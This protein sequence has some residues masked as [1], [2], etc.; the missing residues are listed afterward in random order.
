MSI[1]SLAFNAL[2]GLVSNK[3]Y[4]DLNDAGTAA[5]YIVYSRAGGTEAVFLE[6]AVSSK[7]TPRLQVTCWHTT[8]IGANAL[9]EQALAA[10]VALG[11]RPLGGV[12]G[13]HDP[14]TKLRG[15]IRDFSAWADR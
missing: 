5:P 6:N 11:W 2:K 13:T 12:I 10:L 14:V 9:A 1:E 15:A 8:R 7:E 4:P 3:V